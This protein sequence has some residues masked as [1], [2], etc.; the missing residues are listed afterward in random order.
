MILLGTLERY[1]RVTQQYHLD[2]SRNMGFLERSTERKAYSL[3]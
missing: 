3:N 1:H 2:L